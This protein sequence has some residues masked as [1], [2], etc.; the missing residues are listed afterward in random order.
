[1]SYCATE[2]MDVRKYKLYLDMYVCMYV[3]IA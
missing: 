2:N 1:M 3:C